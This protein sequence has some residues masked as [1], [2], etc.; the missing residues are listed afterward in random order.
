MYSVVMTKSFD[1]ALA[2]LSASWQKLIVAKIKQLAADP[3]APNNNLKKLQGRNGYRLRIGD[4][5]VIYELHDDRLV[6]LVWKSEREEK[7]TDANRKNHPWRQR[8]R[9]SADG[10]AE[11][12]DGR[13]RN[14][15]G[16]QG[17]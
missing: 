6:M 11:E 9:H 15:G 3:Y 17:L 8:V 1:K 10:R 4:W 16:R 7:Y 2:K 13:R 5:R 14:A 12:T